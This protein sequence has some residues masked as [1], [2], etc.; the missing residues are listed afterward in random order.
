MFS[1]KVALK[2]EDNIRSRDLY[3][4]GDRYGLDLPPLGRR[5]T[6]AE[7]EEEFVSTLISRIPGLRLL[8]RP[9]ERAYVTYLNVLRS[10]VFDYWA[11]RAINSGITPTDNPMHFRQ[12]AKF[13]NASTGRG[14]MTFGDAAPYLNAAF[15]SPKLTVAR[16]EYPYR[17][18]KNSVLGPINAAYLKA[19]GKPLTSEAQGRMLMARFAA[20]Q[21]VANGVFVMGTAY[22]LK[23]ASDTF[24]WDVEMEL[25]PRSRN[26]MRVRIGKNKFIDM[27]GGMGP[28]LRLL[29]QIATGKTKDARTGKIGKTPV[30]VAITYWGASKLS[31][32]GGTVMNVAEGKRFGGKPL[33]VGG[34]ASDLVIPITMEQAYQAWQEEGMDGL[35]LM[36]PETLGMGVYIDERQQ[37]A[38]APRPPAPK[39]R[40]PRSRTPARTSPR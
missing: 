11:N 4:L 29:T 2:I 23:V 32:A 26:F 37:S 34:V 10:Q 28:Q 31:P 24:G 36:A 8:T 27:S 35:W 9:S 5:A 6:A 1:E 39:K 20:R 22:M 40:R 25:D 19:R 7:R 38:I 21:I 3:L 14:N 33:T 13:I 12:L 15:F 17:L 30:K 18:A 16:F